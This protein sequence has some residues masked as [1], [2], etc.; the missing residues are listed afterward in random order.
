MWIPVISPLMNQ[1]SPGEEVS[2]TCDAPGCN[3]TVILSPEKAKESKRLNQGR[4]VG[5]CPE[6]LERL[7]AGRISD[8]D[9]TTNP[10]LNR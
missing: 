9:P 10:D 8:N 3:H 1:L 6:H 4:L 5:Y 2:V 7:T